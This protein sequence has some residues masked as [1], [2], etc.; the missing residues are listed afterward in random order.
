[1][2]RPIVLSN[3]H[4]HVGINKT[5]FV[6]DLYFPYV[7]FENHAS[8]RQSRHKIGVWVDGQFSW[9]DDGSWQFTFETHQQALI[10]HTVATNHKLELALEFDDFVHAHSNSFVRLV[11]VINMS[12][13]DKSVRLFMHQAF[14]IGNS[15]NNTD[16]AQNLPDSNA[17]L[18]YRGDRAFVISGRDDAD[19]F[20]DQHS[21]GLFGIEDHEGTYKD[22]EDGE[23]SGANVEH[24]QVDSVLRFSLEVPRFGSRRTSY[25]IAAGLSPREAIDS[26]RYICETGPLSLHHHTSVWWHEWLQPALEYSVSFEPARRNL[27]LHSVMI[28]KSH[29]SDNGA[30]IASTDSAM[31]NYARDNYAYSWPRDG[32]YVLWPL[33]RLGYTDEALNFFR[34]CKESL[35][36]QGYLMHKYRADGALG[37]SW[38]PYVHGPINAPPIQE[39]E[40]ALVLFMFLQLYELQPETELLDEFY[41]SFIKPSADFIAS[42]IDHS[43]GLPK[44][45]YELW[46]EAFMT[47][48]YTTAVVHSALLASA[49]LAEAAQRSNDAVTWRSAAGDIQSAAK[50]LYNYDRKAFYKGLRYDTGQPVPD[51]TID[52]SSFFGAYLYGLFSTDSSEVRDA[53]KT[54]KS[55]LENKHGKLYPRYEGDNYHRESDQPNP[56]FVTSLWMAQYYIE[57]DEREAAASIMQL[58]EQYV[59]GS[60]ML[61]EQVSAVNL[62]PRSV[63]PLAWSHA[64][65]LA[66]VLDYQ[67]KFGAKDD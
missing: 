42:Y 26:H 13:A 50:Q 49:E 34:F 54:L 40:T 56:W 53:A 10:G 43:T 41:D 65:Y 5:G 51:E 46:E 58:V 18:H 4:L 29:C 60:Q 15:G 55:T 25:W 66:S 19:N 9:L 57:V 1:M 30:I 36:P 52:V 62:E 14:E 67:S 11:H 44:P 47:S 21:I 37:S 64:E 27:F 17:L 23:L 3:G 38:H 16:T 2:A 63:S 6:H 22:A 61:P 12:G 39:D 28:L 24:G 59:D 7:G 33:M 8:G 35:H 45:T 32:A 48:T 20:Y 31:L